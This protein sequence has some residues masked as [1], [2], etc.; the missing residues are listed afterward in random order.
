MGAKYGSRVDD[1]E[2]GPG[3]YNAN[4][5]LKHNGPKMGTSKRGGLEGRNEG[6]GP[7]QY[8]QSRPF[9]AGPKYGFGN[10]T[11]ANGG[12]D[13]RPGPGQYE[14]GAEQQ[15][16]LKGCTI[17]EKFS[18]KSASNCGPGPGSYDMG[19]KRPQSGA[20]IGK[21]SRITYNDGIGP[22]P[23]AY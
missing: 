8:A 1:P 19:L 12:F 2:P 16:H 4:R 6:P 5:E 9:S 10:E 15:L 22:G 21:A 18:K 14:I 20:K 3:A 17:G 11:K 7:G 23:G 13:Q